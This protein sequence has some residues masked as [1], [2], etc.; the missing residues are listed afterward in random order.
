MAIVVGAVAFLLVLTLGAAIKHDSVVKQA[1]T[2]D[3]QGNY[4]AE[5]KLLG[6]YINSKPPTKY[7]YPILVQLGDLTLKTQKYPA[8]FEWYLRAET[9]GSKPASLH[10]VEGVAKSADAIGDNATAITYCGAIAAT[11]AADNEK[12]GEYEDQIRYLGGKP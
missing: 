4:S 8:A 1:K 9:V 12:I 11:A 5:I 6:D 2:L 3:S 10:V 7:Q